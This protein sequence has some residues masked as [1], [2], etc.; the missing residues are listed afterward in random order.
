MTASS[1]SDFKH[2][3]QTHLKHLK[4]KGLQSKTIGAYARAIRRVG[5]YLD[6]HIDDLS[7]AQLTDYFTDLLASHS[8]SSVKLDLYGLKF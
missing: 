3:Y 1:E 4:L 6:E 5:T 7:V 2:N 8:W